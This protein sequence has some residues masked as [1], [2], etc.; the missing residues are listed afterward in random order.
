MNFNRGHSKRPKV[1][2]YVPT[3]VDVLVQ[4]IEKKD[5]APHERNTRRFIIVNKTH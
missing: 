1:P 2:R 5:T 3:A 4:S